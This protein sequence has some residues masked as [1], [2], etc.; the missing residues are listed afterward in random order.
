MSEL[1][2]QSISSLSDIQ[3]LEKLNSSNFFSWQ[4]GIISSLGMRNLRDI[5]IEPPNSIKINPIYLKKKEM[6]YYF[7]VG[8]L[9]NENYNKF[10]SDE[11]EEPHNL[12]NNIKEHYA[13]S[14]GENI[15]SH[16]GK[17]FSIKFPPS[18]SGL[19]EAISSFCSTLKLFRGLS[20]SLF[21]ADIMV[22]V[23]AFY[24]L[25]LLPETC[26]HVSTAVF[27]SIKVS[28]KIPTVEELF[29]EVELDILRQSGNEDQASL[30]LQLRSEPKKD[31]CHK[32]KHNPLSNH[33]ESE[34]FQLFP[35]KRE[36]YH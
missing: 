22:Q 36:A 27:H 1:S 16:F 14:S 8:H 2:N 30:A 33:S 6:V 12:W 19:S 28:A 21:A 11:D 5:L 34:C 23:L 31:L 32:G 3:G 25:W 7:I 35:E 13:S 17:R 9:D 15:A 4:W 24:I 26:R 18:S 20:P 10:V 29:K